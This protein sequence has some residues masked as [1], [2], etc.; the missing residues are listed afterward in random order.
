MTNMHSGRPLGNA[1]LIVLSSVSATLNTVTLEP[2]TGSEDEAPDNI[3]VERQPDLMDSK[4]EIEVSDDEDADKVREAPPKLEQT[5]R[6]RTI[7][8]S[9]CVLKVLVQAS[10]VPPAKGQAHHP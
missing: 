6:P 3:I 1:R 5:D 4:A 7:K 2:L 9:G 10:D 8:R